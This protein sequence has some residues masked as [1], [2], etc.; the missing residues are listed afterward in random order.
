MSMRIH[1]LEFLL[2]CVDIC[3]QLYLVMK[4]LDTE[5]RNDLLGGGDLLVADLS[6]KSLVTS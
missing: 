2:G 6:L 1:H 3:T 5:R 4:A